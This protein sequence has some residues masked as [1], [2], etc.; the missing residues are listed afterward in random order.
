MITV[1]GTGSTHVYATATHAGRLGARAVAVR[2]PQV[3]NPTAHRVAALARARCAR[4][5][6]LPLAL[7]LPIAARL[8]LAAALGRRVMGGRAQWVPFGGTS[9]LGVLGHVNAALE[10]ADDITAARLPRPDAIVLPIGSAGTTAG[11]LL[12]LTLA[13]LEIPVV[14]ARCGPRIGIT[15]GRVLA[16]MRASVRLVRELAGVDLALPRREQLRID[17]TVYGGAYGR[18]HPAAG[19][20]ADLLKGRT[21]L[22]LDPTYAAKALLAAARH[23]ERAGG[24]RVLLWVTFDGREFATPRTAAAAS[25]HATLVP[26]TISRFAP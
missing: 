12:G 7:A 9:A 25:G 8:R 18:E 16:V 24:S 11:L 20:L 26:D 22:A 6:D 3:M 23:A 21:G 1:G 15:H 2:W 4:V 13:G 17:H 19:R 14:A 5:V 10:L